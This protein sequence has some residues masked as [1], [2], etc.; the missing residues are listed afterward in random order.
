MSASLR[1]R[2][3][4]V[5][6]GCYADA[7]AAIPL[8]VRLATL[9]R[10]EVTGV[11]AEDP[12]A[13]ELPDH[14]VALGRG[15]AMKIDPERMLAAFGADAR[16]FEARLGRAARQES[17]GWRFLRERG[18]V[19]EVLER[20]AQRE[21]VAL[22][23][24]RRALRL[25]GPIVTLGRGIGGDAETVSLAQTLARALVVPLMVL[26]IGGRPGPET[27][28]AIMVS[29]AQAA[30]Q[31]L[32]TLA[33]TALIV[34]AGLAEFATGPALRALIETARCPVLLRGVSPPRGAGTGAGG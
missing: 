2:R 16:A 27:H 12:M 1:I 6:A 10:A 18:A 24:Y 5:V 28:S 31:A 32:D 13:F 25:R 23:G 14:A 26:R 30:L 22:L 4:L 15:G 7:E 21:D 9:A 11:L 34:D 17:L 8:A 29:D 33:P 3:V 20:L 19:P